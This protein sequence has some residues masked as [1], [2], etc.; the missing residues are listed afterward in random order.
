MTTITKRGM[1]NT[2]I[3]A[4]RIK[5]LKIIH[6]RPKRQKRWTK[7]KIHK[8]DPKAKVPYLNPTISIIKC[9]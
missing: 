9:E 8:V 3:R 7:E 1:A 4:D 2:P 6:K 5:S